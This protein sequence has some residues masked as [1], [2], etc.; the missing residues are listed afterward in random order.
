MVILLVKQ[1]IRGVARFFLI[2]H[3]K[4][5]KN[6]PKRGK[7]YQMASF[8]G[9]TQDVYFGIGARGTNSKYVCLTV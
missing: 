5:G 4:M 9:A 8:W 3:A 6:V 2:Q 1:L 7:I